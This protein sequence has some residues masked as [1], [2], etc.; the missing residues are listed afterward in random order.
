[1]AVAFDAM[2]LRPRSG[3][4]DPDFNGR[5]VRRCGGARP[6]TETEAATVDETLQQRYYVWRRLVEEER[7]RG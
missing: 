1:M 2:T 6:L 4:H 3:R 5:S 7:D